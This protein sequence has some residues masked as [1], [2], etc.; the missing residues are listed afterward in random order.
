MREGPQV[1]G[2]RPG[3]LMTGSLLVGFAVVLGAMA[4]ACSSPPT[5]DDPS[6]VVTFAVANG[7]TFR[8]RLIDHADIDLARDLLAGRRD[9]L[10]PIGSIV[11][12]LTDVNTGYSWH[13]DPATVDFAEVAT[14]VCDGLPSHVE[15]GVLAGDTYC[16]WTA[17]VVAIDPQGAPG[18][19][20]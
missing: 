13:L 3:R 18:A 9:G 6:V 1:R 7:E 14:E 2:R 4:A 11:R 12:G 16:P 17:R 15:E 20:T 10:F 5:A 8:V 19:R